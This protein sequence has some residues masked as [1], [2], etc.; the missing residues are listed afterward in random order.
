MKV[1]NVSTELANRA[2]P[3]GAEVQPS[4]MAHFRVW[5]PRRKRVELVIWEAGEDPRKQVELLA[6]EDGYF[7]AFAE[8]E[9][10]TRYA[11]RLDEEDSVYPDPASKRQPDG[12]H[13][14]SEVVNPCTYAWQDLDWT[15]VSIKGQVIYEM[16][17]GTFTNEGTWAAAALELH[18]LADLGVTLIEMMPVA[19]FA[20]H[21]GWGYDGVNLFAPTRLYGA[22][23]D[24]RRFVDKAHACGLGV[25]LDVVYNHFGPSGNYIGQF[26]Q[27][28][29]SRRHRTDWGDAINFDGE[30][31]GPV[32]EF[33]LANAA[34]WIDEFHFD[35][36]RLDAVHAI[37]DD[38]T[39]HILAAV[40]RRVRAAAQGR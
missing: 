24:L 15:G 20:G 21:F 40:A 34:Y 37:L 7:A 11:F 30:N 5:A 16:H 23:D 33:F 38:S 6:E 22:P 39:E 9:V 35:G 31:S 29:V 17:V 19:E 13:G 2:L 10:G 14:P 18:R 12:P 1:P 28:F 25:I 4:G 3:I 8:V 27:D 32:R 26:S 36:L